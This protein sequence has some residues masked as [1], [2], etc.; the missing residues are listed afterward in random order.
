MRP[1]RFSTETL[2]RAENHDY[3]VPQENEIARHR[4]GRSGR[5][6]VSLVVNNQARRGGAGFHFV[7]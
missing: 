7:W 3:D 5:D 4:S 2:D 1:L 6:S